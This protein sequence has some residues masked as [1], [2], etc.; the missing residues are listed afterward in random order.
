MSQ[1]LATADLSPMLWVAPAEY[2]SYRTSE[3]GEKV[4]GS[5]ARQVLSWLGENESRRSLGLRVHARISSKG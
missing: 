5:V 4:E 3:Y 2:V 1:P